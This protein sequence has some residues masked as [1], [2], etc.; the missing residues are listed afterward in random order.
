MSLPRVTSIISPPTGFEA[1]PEGVL[2]AASERGTAVHEACAAYALGLWSPVPEDLQGYFDS[3]K[4]YFD[5]YVVEA[6]AV[7]VE[8]IHPA[9]RYIGHADL[10]AKVRGYV[11]ARPV[12]GVIDYK[13]PVVATP[14]W[15]M[16]LSGYVEAARVEYGAEVGG[17]LQLRKDGSLP[18]MTWVT[19]G[20]Q[21]FA[22][23]L[24]MLNGYNYVNGG[25][26]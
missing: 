24:G 22:A 1:I 21:A 10:I 2:D 7:E 9:F 4:R 14:K 26:G 25:K 11:T 3:F 6:V 20:N 15:R 18:K 5:A 13:T 23:F 12:I 17:A 8:L 19:D 16:Q